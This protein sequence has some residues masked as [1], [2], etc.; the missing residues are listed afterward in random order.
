MILH[1]ALSRVSKAIILAAGLGSRLGSLTYDLPKTLLPIG[2]DTIFDRIVLGLD[3]VGVQ[4]IA[5]VTGHAR[6]ALQSHA[7]SLNKL[8]QNRLNFNFIINNNL[9]IGNI[10]SFYLAQDI[11]FDEDVILLNSDV[12]FHCDLLKLLKNE[13]HSS[14][15]VVDDQKVLGSEEM[16]VRINDVGAIKEITKRLDPSIAN[17]EYIGIMKLSRDVAKKA[18]EKTESLLSTGTYPL[19]YEDALRLVA[20]E[21]DCL[22]ACSTQGLPWTEV[23]TVDDMLFARNIVLPQI[24]GGIQ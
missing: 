12:V 17:G 21:D 14:A 8:V 18:I 22:F 24:L 19:Y 16:K 10:Y 4:D 15:L 9:D 2:N 7:M 3:R 5:V 13:S 20:Q 11:M 23:D 6:S 1:L